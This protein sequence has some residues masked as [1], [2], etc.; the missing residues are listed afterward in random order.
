VKREL[1]SLVTTVPTATPGARQKNRS[2]RLPSCNLKLH[3]CH[4]APEFQLG[5]MRALRESTER[6]H[7]MV[8]LLLMLNQEAIS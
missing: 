8:V 1:R 7:L 6:M 2:E 3:N 4:V 5:A